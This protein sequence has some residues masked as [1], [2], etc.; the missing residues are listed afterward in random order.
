MYRNLDIINLYWLESNRDEVVD[1][2]CRLLP[3][4][5]LLS[6]WLIRTLLLDSGNADSTHVHEKS[7]PDGVGFSLGKL[8]G[9]F[10]RIGTNSCAQRPWLNP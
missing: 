7:Q 10:H 2:H 8:P 1:V 9:R 6:L 4:F 3:S 5:P